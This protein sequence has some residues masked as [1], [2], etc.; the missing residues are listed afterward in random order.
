MKIYC[1]KIF[2]LKRRN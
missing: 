2:S 1:E